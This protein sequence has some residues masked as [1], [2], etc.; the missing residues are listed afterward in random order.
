MLKSHMKA[1][2][3]VL[4]AFCSLATVIAQ[5]NSGVITGRVFWPDGRPVEG[6][7]VAAIPP[8]SSDEGRIRPAVLAETYKSGRYRLEGI[9]P[10]D[11]KVA[12]GRLESA[13]YFPNAKTAAD[14]KAVRVTAG[15][16]VTKIDTKLADPPASM[17]M[18]NPDNLEIDAAT[19]VNRGITSL[20][21]AVA[22]GAS[23]QEVRARLESKTDVNARDVRGWTALM[24]AALSEDTTVT[25]ELLA[26]GADPRARSHAGQTAV[27]AH[28]LAAQT[29]SERIWATHDPIPA[30]RLLL[31]AGADIN[32]TD[33][34]G[35]TPLMRSIPGSL[36][37]DPRLHPLAEI[38]LGG[39]RTD[40]SSPAALARAN[41]VAF[42]KD[43]GARSDPRNAQGL[44]ALD[45]LN[46]EA[47]LLGVP[48]G[49]QFEK[50]KMLL[51]RPAG[52]ARGVRVR[53]TVHPFAGVERLTLRSV[54]IDP[55]SLSSDVGPQGAFEFPAV[56]PGVYLAETVP[57][58]YFP[59]GISPV[60]VPPTDT[61]NL[62]ITL[63][64][65]HPV[66]IRVSV[67]RGTVGH[68]K[69]PEPFSLLLARV[70]PSDKPR[71]FDRIRLMP[72]AVIGYESLTIPESMMTTLS[73]GA[74]VQLITLGEQQ[75]PRIE[76]RGF[77]QPSK[78]P[79]ESVDLLERI[80]ELPAYRDSPIHLKAPAKPGSQSDP[81]MFFYDSRWRSALT[82]AA[83]GSFNML[84]PEGD[85]AVAV[86]MRDTPLGFGGKPD[87]TL[88]SGDLDLTAGTFRV[89]AST[90]R[91]VLIGL[92][93]SMGRRLPFW[94]GY[95][96]G[97]ISLPNGT[98]GERVPVTA[99]AENP[100]QGTWMVGPWILQ[101]RTEGKTFT[102]RLT[103]RGDGYEF[104]DEWLSI[105][106]G[107][108]DG[109][110]VSFRVMDTDNTR[111]ISFSGTLRDDVLTL[112][113]T[114]PGIT[115]LDGNGGVAV[116]A[117]RQAPV[118]Q[119]DAYGHFRVGPLPPGR[120]AIVAGPAEFPTYFPGV[121]AR[122]DATWLTVRERPYSDN[123][124]NSYDP[125][126]Q[127]SLRLIQPASG[128]R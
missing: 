77:G 9:S 4:A 90:G 71:E 85:Y 70:S 35:E 10:G 104:S 54:G 107:R 16:T 119:T 123:V 80:T 93:H 61:A 105:E 82:T 96:A 43:A 14:G 110:T 106:D 83:D 33:R 20:M 116:I 121:A 126:P 112:S 19:G 24:Y 1:W 23:L 2:V 34:T 128:N 84:L 44:T 5:R 127:A 53:G 51:E 101:L 52:Q 87:E 95:I 31:A 76:F 48:P 41:L 37:G 98:P 75:T 100:L 94:D 74:A 73:K 38:S 99:V 21:R 65:F 36:Y 39:P 32:A 25:K 46:E 113:R 45:L 6:I 114:D 120:Y 13:T 122:A 97:T 47:R 72:S 78:P 57:P 79:L 30:L 56:I 60:T 88:R 124:D 12:A 111:R 66:R 7:L 62:R 63:P 109:A 42:L 26:R 28:I 3:I 125:D 27:T 29:F 92:P 15:Q 22:G 64:E 102:G 91:E 117:R 11:Y 58:M 40:D 50:L 118:A 86:G 69:Q 67:A 68:E 89:D 49:S 115:L 59:A 18:P 108:F 81:D 103:T 17:E 55:V 8:S